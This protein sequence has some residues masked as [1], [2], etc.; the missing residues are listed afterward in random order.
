M[1]LTFEPETKGLYKIG[2]RI[3]IPNDNGKEE[4]IYKRYYDEM[5]F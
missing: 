3:S 4:I 2:V 5:H 1:A